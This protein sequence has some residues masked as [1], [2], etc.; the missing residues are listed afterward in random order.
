MPGLTYADYFRQFIKESNLNNESVFSREDVFSWFGKILP[1]AKKVNVEA[2]LL[3]KTSNYPNRVR[4]VPPPSEV[5][6]LFFAEDRDFT[7]F[8]LYQKSVH[9][10]PY[11]KDGELNIHALS[12]VETGESSIETRE[13]REDSFAYEKDLQSFLAKNPDKIETGLRIY[14]ADGITGIEY[15]AGGGRRIDLLCVDR[16]SNWVVVELKV[17]RGYDQV[18]GQLFRYMGW[19]KNN[20]AESNQKVRGIIIARNIS[21]DLKLA[22]S[23]V[24]NVELFEYEMSVKLTNINK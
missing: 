19:V 5:D 7:R 15:P 24:P 22:T 2:Q 23:L 16:D 13:I 1:K 18:A 9:P 4:D 21:E 8:R 17:S 3:K 14:E 10:L 6:D 11:Y 12:S 20:L